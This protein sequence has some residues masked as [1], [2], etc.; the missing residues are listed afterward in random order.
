MMVVTENV[1]ARNGRL[2]REAT[3]YR[4][5]SFE[6]LSQALNM[7]TIRELEDYYAGYPS[8]MHLAPEERQ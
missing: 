7:P 3:E 2:R 4:R 6:L 8:R 1:K 5:Q